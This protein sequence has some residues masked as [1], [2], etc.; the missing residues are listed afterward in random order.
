MEARFQMPWFTTRMSSG[1]QARL[2]LGDEA[3]GLGRV[4]DVGARGP[5]RRLPRCAWSR[6]RRA[7]RLLV[8][9][10]S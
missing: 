10:R 1:P 5:R 6:D 4:R 3:P 8:A 2:G 7:R 9:A